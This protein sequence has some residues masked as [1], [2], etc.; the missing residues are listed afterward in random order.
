MNNFFSTPL[1][2]SQASS[3]VLATEDEH[4][5]SAILFN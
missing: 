2:L 4:K 5:L 3:P 1:D